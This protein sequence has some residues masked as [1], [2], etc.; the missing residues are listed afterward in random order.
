MSEV[1]YIVV[2]EAFLGILACAWLWVITHIDEPTPFAYELEGNCSGL[3]I[4]R[5][6]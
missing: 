1:E 5:V 2:L 4:K 3:P 6:M